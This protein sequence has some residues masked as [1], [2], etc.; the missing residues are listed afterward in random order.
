MKY[1]Y[2]FQ[3]QDGSWS[4]WVPCSRRRYEELQ[5]ADGVQRRATQE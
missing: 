3:E 1:Y 5:D 2:R 4:S